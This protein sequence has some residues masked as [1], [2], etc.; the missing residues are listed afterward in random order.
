M[1]ETKEVN[2]NDCTG[3]WREEKELDMTSG[4]KERKQKTRKKERERKE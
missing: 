3:E 2:V 4:R 1:K